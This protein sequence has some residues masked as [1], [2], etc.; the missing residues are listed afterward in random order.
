MSFVTW[1]QWHFGLMG[2]CKHSLKGLLEKA[3]WFGVPCIQFG[4][5]V[6]HQCASGACRS[7]GCHCM[8]GSSYRYALPSLPLPTCSA[9][10]PSLLWSVCAAPLVHA[11][12]WGLHTCL[13]GVGL[14]GECRWLQA[15]T[16]WGMA[17][18]TQHWGVCYRASATSFTTPLPYPGPA[19]LVGGSVLH[20]GR[21][22]MWD[23]GARL[24]GCRW[25]NGSL[26]EGWGVGSGG[27]ALGC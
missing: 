21:L 23:K 9:L 5:C 25:W 2:C 17:A 22:G 6:H 13:V 16:G 4:P 7:A 26:G 19:C 10:S 24:G 3:R 27:K 20:R 15:A 11:G 14:G 8:A 12:S 1:W 18:P